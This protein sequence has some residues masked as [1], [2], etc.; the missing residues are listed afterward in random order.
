MKQLLLSLCLVI[1]APDCFANQQ[2]TPQADE[3]IAA[4]KV[5]IKR[6]AATLQTEL[7]TAMQGGGPIAAVA[8]CNTKAIPL[9]SQISAE[10]GMNL[11]RVSLKNRNPSNMPN[12]WQRVVLKDFEA[13]S[14]AGKPVSEIAWSDT[15]SVDGGQEFRF[16][17]AIPT[18]RVCLGC[19]GS[20]I[21]P[22]LKQQLQAL[23]PQD[24]A[25]GFGEG[26]IRGAFVVTRRLGE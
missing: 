10:Q 3:N 11:S 17:K 24:Q 22:A 19:H 14:L 8:V 7:K 23:Y 1:L 20:D 12:K 26:D 13:L 9:T 2:V 25:T 4:A 18:S 5:A 21:S 16:M 15:V 6:L